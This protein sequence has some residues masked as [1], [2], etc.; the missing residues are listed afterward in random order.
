MIE[1]LSKLEEI[2]KEKRVC[3]LSQRYERAAQLRDSERKV[4]LEILEVLE[5]SDH[6]SSDYGK[7]DKF[8][9]EK[10][11]DY[12]NE[13]YKYDIDYEDVRAGIFKS[14]IREIKLSKLL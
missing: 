12:I 5:I 13:K 8:V 9:N 11:M 14:L 7:N 6:E 10:I 2:R 3:I 1:L 4:H